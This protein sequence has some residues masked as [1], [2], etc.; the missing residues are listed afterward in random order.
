MVWTCFGELLTMLASPVIKGTS[1]LADKLLRLL[2][3]ISLGQL[4]VLK[5]QDDSARHEENTEGVLL[6][7]KAVEEA[8]FQLAVEVLTS[9]A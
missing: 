8:K 3:L 2:F 7:D 1:L 5:S 9:K 4:D 6:E